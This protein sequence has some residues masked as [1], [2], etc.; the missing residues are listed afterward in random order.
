MFMCALILFALVNMHAA[1][2]TFCNH[3]FFQCRM[4]VQFLFLTLSTTNCCFHFRGHEH[5][6]IP[7]RVR[8]CNLHALSPTVNASIANRACNHCQGCSW[9]EPHLRIESVFEVVVSLKHFEEPFS[10]VHKCLYNIF[11]HLTCFSAVR[12]C[13]GV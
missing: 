9:I 1:V 2:S 5:I 6:L 10:T 7:V 3:R 13:L 11:C 4:E 12:I 8:S